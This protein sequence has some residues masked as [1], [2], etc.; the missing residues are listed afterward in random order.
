MELIPR[1]RSQLVDLVATGVLLLDQ[2][3][4]ILYANPA[5][6]RLLHATGELTGQAIG[7][8]L[9]DWQSLRQAAPGKIQDILLINSRGKSHALHMR[10]FSVQDAETGLNYPLVTLYDVSR[11]KEAEKAEREQRALAEAL[12]DIVS[13]LNSAL[14]IEIILD[15]ILINLG[16]VVAL[17]AANIG[18]LN[19][20]GLVRLRRWQGYQRIGVYAELDSLELKPTEIATWRKMIETHRPVVVADTARDEHWAALPGTSWIGSYMGA[21]ILIKDE[22][23][24]F[25]NVDSAHPGFYTPAIAER[26]QAFADEAAVAIEKANLFAE[27]RRRA[28]ALEIVYRIS[29][30]T[31]AGLEVDRVLVTLLDQCRQFI[32]IDIFYIAFYDDKSG[33]IDIPLLYEKDEYHR[34]PTSNIR[35]QRGLTCYV[36]ETR[37]SYVIQDALAPDFNPPVPL[38]RAGG[39]PSRTYVGVPM[40]LRDQVVGVIS[41]QNYQPYAYTTEQVRLLETIATQAALTLENARMYQRMEQLATIDSLTDL[42][43]RRQFLALGVREIDRARRHRQPL[44]AIM[45]DIDFFKRVN[46]AHGHTSGDRVLAAIALVCRQ[47]LRSIDI[48]GRYGGDE[49][50]ILLPETEAEEAR[51]VAERLRLMI[52]TR[53]VQLPQGAVRVTASFG[54]AEL[55]ARQR[56][57]L[58]LLDRADKAMYEAKQG[59]R[60]QVKMAK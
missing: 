53:E 47:T 8:L 15:H 34:G 58:D 40:I 57:I 41:M 25:I 55:S 38:L 27:T 4:R 19:E 39:N 12:R 32:P 26:L 54:V 56:D 23:I 5:A 11:L 33:S 35:D 59:G 21:P 49:I 24:G 46:D 7:G 20:R 22:V 16:R 48:V 37:K 3:E 14:D 28:E 2:E 44:S 17:D 10:L 18:I 6:R 51:I 52:E 9:T 13:A 29:L 30:A 60:N 36:I 50:V 31:A 42:Y 1:L 45:M 43:N